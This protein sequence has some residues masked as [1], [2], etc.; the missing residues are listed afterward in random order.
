MVLLIL[1]DRVSDRGTINLDWVKLVKKW[2]NTGGER[3]MESYGEN[4]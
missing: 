3:E 2:Q 1:R 4:E